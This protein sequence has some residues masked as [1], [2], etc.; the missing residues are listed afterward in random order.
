MENRHTKIDF[1]IIEDDFDTVNLLKTFIEAQGYTCKHAGSVMK[2]LEILNNNI[3]S[4][5]L[6][7][8]LLP[9]KKGHE[10]IKP[11]K[12]NLL[13]NDVLIYFLTAIPRPE[14]LKVM[15]KYGANGVITKPFDI[16]EIDSLFKILEKK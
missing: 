7:D 16:K 10:L 13:F 15:E 12:S 3:P 9:D 11:I 1:L 6:L 14:A 2:G 4:I 5:I 8:L